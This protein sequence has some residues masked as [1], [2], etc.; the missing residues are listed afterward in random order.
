MIKIKGI[1]EFCTRPAVVPGKSRI[2]GLFKVKSSQEK[3]EQRDNKGTLGTFLAVGISI[4]VYFGAAFVF[5]GVLPNETLMIDYGSMKRV[6]RFGFLIDAGVIAATLS[7]GMA[8]FLGA[9]R[10]LQSLAADRISPFLLPF[11]KG[12]GPAENPRRGVLL[13][14]GRNSG[15]CRKL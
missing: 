8:S 1:R 9:P 14:A 3:I 11:A 10:I 7:S 2:L 12:T 13:S 15:A 4:L 5:A 6:A